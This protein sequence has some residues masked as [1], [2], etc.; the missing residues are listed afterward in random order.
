MDLFLEIEAFGFMI[1]GAGREVEWTQV[2]DYAN[3]KSLSDP[4]RYQHTVFQKF[5]ERKILKKD[6]LFLILGSIGFH[7]NLLQ[8]E[9][10]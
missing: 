3:N 9:I 10:F 8:S 2:G 5:Q 7:L 1:H 6:F 4:S